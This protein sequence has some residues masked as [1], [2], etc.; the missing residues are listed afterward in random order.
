MSDASIPIPGDLLSHESIKDYPNIVA[1]H[2]EHGGIPADADEGV[3][4]EIMEFT[5]AIAHNNV[6]PTRMRRSD[7]SPRRSARVFRAEVLGHREPSVSPERRRSISQTR[8]SRDP[9]P[10]LS[11]GDNISP[12]RSRSRYR[13]RS[14][15][16]NTIREEP[17]F[18]REGRFGW[19]QHHPTAHGSGTPGRRDEPE[20]KETAGTQVRIGPDP[21]KAL[22]NRLHTLTQQQHNFYDRVM[23]AI[24][25]IEVEQSQIQAR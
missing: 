21:A 5:N 14:R 20:P 8:A 9:A 23:H 18:D 1:M 12:V 17:E 7:P 11:A 10:S 4:E 15:P 25:E 16:P 3:L 6:D 19:D 22:E 13:S 24:G 2:E